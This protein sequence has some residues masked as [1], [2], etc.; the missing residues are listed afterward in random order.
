MSAFTAANL[1]SRPTASAPESKAPPSV[2]AIDDALV[3][4][5]ELKK[6]VY[7]AIEED[8]AQQPLFSDL[9]AYILKLRNAQHGSNGTA[10]SNTEP[11]SKKRK[12]EGGETTN[13]AHNGATNN[14][15][16]ADAGV[17]ADYVVPDTS[18]AVPQ[19]KKFA[20]E[21][22]ADGLR[23]RTAGQGAV[24]FGIGFA[25]IEQIF[26]LP[27]PEKAKRQW[28]FVVVPRTNDGLTAAAEGAPQHE[29]IVWTFQEPTAKEV[30]K[31]AQATYEP[32]VERLNAC[33]KPHRKSIVFPTKEEFQSA[34]PQSHRKGEPGFHVKAHRGSKEGYLFFTNVGIIFGFKK[35]LLYF[36]FAAIESISYTSVLQR[37]F[38]LNVTTAAAEPEQKVQEIEFSMLDQADYGGIDEYVRTHGLNDASMAAQRRAQKYNVNGQEGAG[39][40]EG[41]EADEEDGET[42]LQKA[43]RMLE[44][45]EDEDEEDYDPGSEG[46]SEGSGSSSEEESEDDEDEEEGGSGAEDANLVAAELGSEAEDVELSD[47]E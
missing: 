23:A 3:D 27:V 11:A 44:D 21:I 30:E 2:P 17:S 47:A 29:Q 28:S 37:T 12:I 24:E 26:C 16:W 6:R 45:E 9:S 18:F 13:A 35:P 10:A 19:R 4:V 20:L 40:A 36:S 43:E 38:N 15:A 42:E 14:G 5:P 33:L 25:D 32:L 39:G 8:P 22:M 34:I 1:P 46:E 7:S 31:G 41:V